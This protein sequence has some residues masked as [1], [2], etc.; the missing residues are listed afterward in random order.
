M[1][2]KP[3][4]LAIRVRAGFCK[5]IPVGAVVQV[6][7]CYG[8]GFSRSSGSA[9][10]NIWSVEYQGQHRDINGCLHG[11]PD[12][13]LRP[14]RDNDGEDEMLRIAGLPHDHKQPQEA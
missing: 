12:S 11:V 4:D 7:E 13:D 1:N 8:S 9:A 10:Q 2:C 14:L 5:L 3:G 6:L